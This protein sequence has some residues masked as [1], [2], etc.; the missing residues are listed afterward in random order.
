MDK[1]NSLPEE[2]YRIIYDFIPLFTK[3]YLSKNNF[4]FYYQS[5]IS[6]LDLNN[7]KKHDRYIRD[8]I[9]NGREISFS[10]IIKPG[11]SIWKKDRLWKWKNMRFP[12]YLIYVRHLS[13]IYNQTN[14]KNLIDE[15]IKKVLS[16]NKY[17]KI[18]SN[19]ILWSN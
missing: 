11:L 17:K 15:K 10:L 4:Q 14:L 16:R 7:Y 12:N 1:L 18:R 19:N 2:L 8:I 3:S 5:K 9:R 13:I 6:K